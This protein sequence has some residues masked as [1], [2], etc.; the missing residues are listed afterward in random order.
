[1]NRLIVLILLFFLL[2]NCSFNEKSGIWKNK[3]K[4]LENQKNIEQVFSEKK[5]IYLNLIQN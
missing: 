4:T 5:K 1:M 3:E 2:N